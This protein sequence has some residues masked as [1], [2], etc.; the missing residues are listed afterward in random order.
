MLKEDD[1]R[2]RALGQPDVGVDGLVRDNVDVVEVWTK[3]GG[4]ELGLL[5]DSISREQSEPV[6]RPT[7]A[8][9]SATSSTSS[10]LCSA[11]PRR[12]DCRTEGAMASVVRVTA[13]ASARARSTRWR[14]HRRSRGLVA[15]WEFS[16]TN[17][18]RG[19]AL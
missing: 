13:G 2:L 7:C 1:D 12:V 17:A 16:L 8:R 15:S 4:V 14:T 6:R 11:G 5:L 10:I 3:S 18:D 9:I 19:P